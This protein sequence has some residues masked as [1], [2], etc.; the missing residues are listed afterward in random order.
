MSWVPLQ[1]VL[2]PGFLADPAAQPEMVSFLLKHGA[3]PRQKLPFDT[4]RTVIGFAKAIKSP[5]LTLLDAPAPALPS[6]IP[7]TALAS[8]AEM[9]GGARPQREASLRPA[10]ARFDVPATAGESSSR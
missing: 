1:R 8:T 3:N 4:S 9:A 2:L 7:T 5:V 6:A 10:T